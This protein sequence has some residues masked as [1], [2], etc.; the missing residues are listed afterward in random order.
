MNAPV[1]RIVKPGVT[2]PVRSIGVA[3]R[4]NEPS[5]QSNGILF[6]IV[7]FPVIIEPLRDLLDLRVSNYARSRREPRQITDYKPV[8]G[9]G[10][11]LVSGTEFRLR[12]AQSPQ[13]Q[14]RRWPPS[15]PALTKMMNSSCVRN[16]IM[17][18]RHSVQLT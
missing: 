7:G 16:A 11:T 5:D 10:R 6:H 12:T 2:F 15:F 3:Q 9:H 13:R 8:V 4:I 1:I 17:A 18:R 14:L